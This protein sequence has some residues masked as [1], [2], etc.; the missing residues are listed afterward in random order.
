MCA[1]YCFR[2]I[3]NMKWLK[4]NLVHQFCVCLTHAQE[5]ITTLK[6]SFQGRNLFDVDNASI[7]ISMTH[8]TCCC[9][10]IFFSPFQGPLKKREIRR[11]FQASACL[12]ALIW[13]ENLTITRQTWDQRDES[14]TWY[15]ACA[16][17]STLTT[18][19][20]IQMCAKVKALC[21]CLR[22][23]MKDVL[24]WSFK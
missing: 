2:W 18:G 8:F 23:Q 14:W 17:V 3:W 15:V 11:F 21:L 19:A 5:G 24:F 16:W 12:F 6:Y 9:K 20:S 10:S 4:K 13:K 1:F 7:F 22:F